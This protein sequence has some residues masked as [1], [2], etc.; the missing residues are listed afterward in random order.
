MLRKDGN[1]GF[2]DDAHSLLTIN[3]LSDTTP[4]VIELEFVIIM[5]IHTP[6]LVHCLFVCSVFNLV[7]I[8][9]FGC[10]GSV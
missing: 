9:L 8:C 2:A 7:V 10:N 1:C 4:S 6:G 5:L 3:Q